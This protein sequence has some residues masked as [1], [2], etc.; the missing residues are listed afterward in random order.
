M[1]KQTTK[2]AIATSLYDL[3]HEK[4]FDKITVESI[5]ETAQVSRR[6]FYRHFADKFA[7]LNWL[8]RERYFSKIEIS[9]EGSVWDLLPPICEQFYAD[10]AFFRNVIQITGQNSF[11]V[12]CMELIYPYVIRNLRRR[13]VRP[14]EKI[15]RLYVNR[16]LE[17]VFD[18]VLDW[19]KREPCTDP[20]QFAKSIRRAFAI[21]SK[22]TWQIAT[23]GL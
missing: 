7:L 20:Q 8:Y 6:N 5:C 9:E 10:R 16:L 1:S 15:L 13:G 3:M 21:Y 14:T 23:E 22:Y 18:Y 12:Y 2:N 19:L 17:A 11:R 4:A